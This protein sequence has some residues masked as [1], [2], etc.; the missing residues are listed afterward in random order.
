MSLVRETDDSNER[1][2]EILTEKIVTLMKVS[3]GMNIAVWGLAFKAG[4]DD[5]RDSPAVDLARILLDR[6]AYVRAHD[7]VAAA[8]F[9]RDHADLDVEVRDDVGDAATGCDGLVL[10]TEW[11]EYRHLDWQAIVR[12]VRA[13][14]VVDGRNY[15][16]VEAL[17]SAGFKVL[18]VGR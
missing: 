12:R 11:P 8:S 14:V 9:R 1:H 2:K 5:V 10:C 17:T 16:D 6:A 4:T 13:P 3:G 7:P 15:L 18:R